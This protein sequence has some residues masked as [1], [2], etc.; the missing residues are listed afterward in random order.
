MTHWYDVI[1]DKFILNTAS[2]TLVFDPDFLCSDTRII[3]SLEGKGFSWLIYEDILTFRYEFETQIRNRSKNQ[4]YQNILLVFQESITSSASLPYDIISQADREISLSLADIF[5]TFS[6]P[7]LRALHRNRTLSIEGHHLFEA[8]YTAARQSTNASKKLTEDETQDF[9]L[10]HIFQITLETV[11]TPSS[12]LS[13]LLRLH[14]SG[15]TLPDILSQYLIEQLESHANLSSFPLQTIICDRQAFFQFLQQHWPDY[16]KQEIQKGT[17]LVGDRGSLSDYETSSSGLSLPFGD[18]A[19][20]AYIDSL[21][22]EGYL[23][24]V[25]PSQLGLGHSLIPPEAWFRI[26]LELDPEAEIQ[27]RFER[28]TEKLTVNIPTTD[29]EATEWLS[30]AFQ[31]ANLLV[32]WY[33]IPAPQPADLSH[34]FHRLQ[35]TADAQFLGWVIHQYH[36][37]HYQSPIKPV[38]VHHIPRFLA[39]QREIGHLDKVALILMDGLALD[40]WLAIRPIL[41]NQLPNLTFRQQ[42]VFAWLPTITSVSRQAL[43]AGKPPI[44]FPQSILRTKREPKLWE[45]FWVDHGLPPS[46]VTYRAG[47]RNLDQITDLQETI[48]HPQIKILGLVVDKVDRISHHKESGTPVMH[49]QIRPWVEQGFMAALLSLLVEHRFKVFITADHGNIETTGIGSPAEKAIADY[50]GQRVRIYPDQALRSQVKE[51]FPQAI[52]WD[53]PVLPADFLPLLAPGRTAFITEGDVMITHG[54]ISMEELIVP[55]I[56]VDQTAP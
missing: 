26:G 55:F 50:R 54:G 45:Q 48:T 53:S 30:F 34:G 24:P 29:G 25:S 16:L 14:Y 15:Y 38:M 36:T 27:E 21:F 18:K 43:F 49:Q 9:I 56:E 20:R 31:W 44:G 51:H 2:L 8:L 41:A 11:Q 39:R 40:Q 22:L 47:L 33:Q 52:E 12:L 46:Q 5:P 10:K 7:I 6:Y 19:V 17:I 28:L 35:A 23:K 37:L 42:S 3:H 32:L 1:A 4:N 13:S